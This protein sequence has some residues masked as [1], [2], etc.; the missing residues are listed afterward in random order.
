[1][2][3]IACD[4]CMYTICVLQ[5]VGLTSLL[6]NHSSA[7]SSGA[8]AG[9]CLYEWLD[10]NWHQ[11]VGVTGCYGPI[12]YGS[13]GFDPSQCDWKAHVDCPESD[14]W[15]H[16]LCGYQSAAFD[17]Y[18]NT[19]WF[20]L[21]KVYPHPGGDMDIIVPRLAYNRIK[22]LYGGEEMNHGL[23]WLW[24]TLFLF[25]I[26]TITSTLLYIQWQHR[27]REL[28]NVGVQKKLFDIGR[29]HGIS[30]SPYDDAPLLDED[31]RPI[32]EHSDKL[33][34]SR[35]EEGP[36]NEQTPLIGTR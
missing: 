7:D 1:M 20:G 16:A 19:A 9:G 31:G 23:L 13:P 25:F 6:L 17:H 30:S 15:Y 8:V 35:D 27:C 24:L 29:D 2:L 14:L 32:E 33:D 21:M 34:D 22:A 5:V 36:L 3:C 4:V 28:A 10:E 12:P 18:T 11:T 26:A